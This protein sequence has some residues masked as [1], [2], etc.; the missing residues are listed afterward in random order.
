MASIA[1]Q[2]IGKGGY[3]VVLEG[4]QPVR[5]ECSLTKRDAESFADDL[6]AALHEWRTEA[7]NEGNYREL[8]ARVATDGVAEV[9]L[10]NDAPR[11]SN[12]TVG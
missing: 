9:A 7:A 10:E 12:A 11:E 8:Q 5:V 4:E 6:R 3:T 1:V 2:P